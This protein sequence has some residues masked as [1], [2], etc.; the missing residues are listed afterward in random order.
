MSCPNFQALGVD[1]FPANCAGR[2]ALPFHFLIADGARCIFVEGRKV[3]AVIAMGIEIFVFGF[4][5]WLVLGFFLLH[6]FESYQSVEF[7]INIGSYINDEYTLP[8]YGMCFRNP[9]FFEQD[10]QRVY[11][12]I[13]TDD[14]ARAA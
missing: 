3:L 1:G 8:K 6:V 2:I 13:I 12:V 11:A 9:I 4:K 10:K 7:R 5:L 14:T